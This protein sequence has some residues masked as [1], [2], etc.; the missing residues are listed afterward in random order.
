MTLLWEGSAPDTTVKTETYWPAIDPVTGDVWVS[1]EFTD[2]FW[3][4]GPDGTF[5]EAWGTPGH[6]DGQFQLRPPRNPNPGVS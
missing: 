4:F 5:K 2:Q 1:S 3:I 6:G